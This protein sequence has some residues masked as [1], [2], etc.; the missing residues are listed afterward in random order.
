M[1][2]PDPTLDHDEALQRPAPSHLPVSDCPLL[3]GAAVTLLPS[4]ANTLDAIFA[5]ITDARQHLHM[6]YY[7]FEDIHWHGRSLIDLLVEK[8]RQGV[9]VALSFDGAGSSG[10][11]DAVFDRLRQAGGTLLEFR[12]L[13]PLRRRFNPLKLNDRDHRKLLVVDGRIA[14][15]GGVNLSRVYEN[16]RSAGAAADTA[17]AFWYDAAV[18]IA[19]P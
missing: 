14:F 12:P 5:A 3:D 6:E 4:G 1:D 9:C 18:R 8:L 17:K 2:A 19:G 13:S 16:P 11:S 10:T 15:L 7:T